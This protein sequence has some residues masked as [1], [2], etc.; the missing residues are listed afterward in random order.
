MDTWPGHTKTREHG[1][2]GGCYPA[3]SAF[4]RFCGVWLITIDIMIAN[5]LYMQ[6]MALAPGP[7]AK[8]PIGLLI[9]SCNIFNDWRRGHELGSS[10]HPKTNG[11]S[12][13]LAA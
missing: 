1:R 13:E 4:G 10:G 6:S 2:V 5:F 9:E 12:L 11:V 3:P 8:L 7:D